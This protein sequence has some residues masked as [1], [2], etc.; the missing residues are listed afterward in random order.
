MPPMLSPTDFANLPGIVR[1]ALWT[2]LGAFCLIGFTT[3]AKHLT[4]ELPIIVMVFFR[5]LFGL[6]F[7]VPWLMRNGID[8]LRTTRPVLMASR[9]LNTLFGLYFMFAAVALI[10]IADVVAILYAKPLFASLA[11][12]LI[13]GEVMYAR[14]W[15]ALAVGAIGMLLIVRPGFVEL[16]YGVLFALLAMTSGAYTTITVKIL[17]R[18]ES[19]DAIVAWALLGVLLTSLI[20]ALMDW[21]T[22]NGEQLLWLVAVGGLATGFQR[23]LTRAYAAADATAVMP[24]EFSRLIFAAVIGFV[25][26]GQLPDVWTWAGGTV[27]FAAAFYMVHREARYGKPA[28]TDADPA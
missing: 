21:Q 23:C 8:G 3:I 24:F 15:T 25:V 7:L 2:V 10:P 16:N 26:F 1:A 12:V 22:P 19:P 4:A 5:A 13:L 14:R 28:A 17:T 6:L 11:A 27:I 9:G 20:P 18:T